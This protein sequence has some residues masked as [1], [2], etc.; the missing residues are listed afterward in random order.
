M[1]MQL[2]DP[3][4][5]ISHIRIMDEMSMATTNTKY[6]RMEKRKPVISNQLMV[7]S[8]IAKLLFER[9]E[10]P[11]NPNNLITGYTPY[12]VIQGGARRILVQPSWL[13]LFYVG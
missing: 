7:F 6:L 1:S 13:C 4:I 2:L 3:D 12:L 8:N 11:N 9:C 5:W 10:Y